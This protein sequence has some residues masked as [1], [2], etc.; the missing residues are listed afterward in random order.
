MTQEMDK[1]Y[2]RSL[3][4]W[5]LVANRI[6]A[7]ADSRQRQAIEAL[8]GTY[9][10]HA[11]TSEQKTAL[12]ERGQQSLTLIEESLAARRVVGK[13][14]SAL[15]EKNA[16]AGV[17]QLLAEIESKRKELALLREVEGIDL[18]TRVG[19]NEIGEALE[20]RTGNESNMTP[21]A[22]SSRGMSGSA[23]GVPV[24]LVAYKDLA[25]FRERTVAMEAE[26]NALTD[27]VNDMNRGELTLAIPDAMATAAGLNE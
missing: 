2:T 6:G 5:H 13:I 20:K 19:I 11:P 25:V 9:L 12:T 16:A 18:L 8:G 3:S 10:Q 23:R 22:I 17:S 26:V 24:A 21:Y 1:K 15:A 4:R 27:K 14:R 7:L